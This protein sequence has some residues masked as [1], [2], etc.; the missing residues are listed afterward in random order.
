MRW[1]LM[2]NLVVVTALVGIARAEGKL[3]CPMGQTPKSDEIQIGWLT[4]VRVT[5]QF[6]HDIETETT[7]V[8][9]FR[10]VARIRK[11]EALEP[12]GAV[13]VEGMQFWSA[14][15]KGKRGPKLRSVRSFVDHMNETHCEYFADLDQP[16]Y[17][18][19]TL[20]SSQP[21]PGYFRL[22]TA[23]ERVK[24]YRDNTTCIDQGDPPENK[25]PPCSRPRILAVSDKPKLRYWATEPYKWDTGLSVWEDQGEKLVPILRV[26]VGCSD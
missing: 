1:L 11:G 19:W 9:P 4:D 25:V 23:R 14:L 17:K 12:T 15:R 7:T 13:L 3:E 26:C 16:G 18:R 24:F 8:G 20:F 22:P 21:I 2:V 5:T 6:G 10:L